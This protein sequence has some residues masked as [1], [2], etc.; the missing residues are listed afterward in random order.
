MGTFKTQMLWDSIRKGDLTATIGLLQSGNINLEERDENGQTFLMLACEFGELNIVRELFEANV[1]INAVDKDNWS[2]LMYSAKEGHLE[3]VIE[4]LERGANIEH[5]DLSGWTALM[6]ASYKGKHLVVQE[7]LERGANPN[8]KAELSM[9]SLA[10]AAG[11]GHTKVVEVLLQKGAKINTSDKYGTTALIWAARKGYLEIVE[12]LLNE[13]AIVDAVGM[14]SWTALLVATKGGFSEVVHQ[15]L[16]YD[17]NVNALDKDGFTALTIAAKEGNFQVV[18]DLLGKGAYVNIADRAGDTILIHAVKG[19]HVE[20][21]RALVKKFADVD[22]EGSEGKTALYWAIEKGHVEISRFILENNPDLEIATKDGDTALLRAVRNRNEQC[23]RLLLDKGARVSAVDKRGDTALHI[24]LRARSKRITELLLRNPRNSRLL[25]RPNKAGETPYNIDAYHQRQILTQIFGHRNLNANDGENLLGYDIYSSALADILSEPSLN[26]PITIGLYAKWGSGKSFLLSKLQREMKS[27][28]RA[29]KDEHF[30]FCWTLFI[31]LLLINNIIGLTLALSVRWEVGLGVGLGLFPLQYAFLGVVYVLSHKYNIQFA[32]RISLLLGR[33][34]MVLTLLLDV[35]FFNPKH[36]SQK[37]KYMEP[38][39]RF[40]FSESTKLT[41]VG[42]EKALAAMIGT[43]ADSLEREYG[44]VVA[45]LFRVFKPQPDKS[46]TGKFK[47]LCCIPYFVIVYAVFLSIEVGIYL[48]VSYKLYNPPSSRT[49]TQT[50][51]N[52]STTPPTGAS[53]QFDLPEDNTTI[54]AI[55]ITIGCI[56]VLALLS[57]IYTL[58]QAVMALVKSQRH[59][60]MQA[61]DQIDEIKID[62]LMQKLKYEVSLMGKLVTCMDKFTQNQTRLVVI[63]DGLDSCEQDKVLQVLDIIK[64]LF[65]DEDS[66]FITIL[67]ID[68]QVIIKGIDSNIL[69]TRVTFQDTNVN[70]FDYLRNVVHLP[71]YLQGQG[72]AVKKQDMAPS[73]SSASN[74]VSRHTGSESPS[75]TNRNIQHQESTISSSSIYE[76]KNKNRRSREDSFAMSYQSTFDLTSG[77]N[78]TDYFSDINPRSV[79]RLMNIV[80]VTGRILRAYN[81]DFNWHRLAS[82]INI[83]EQWPYRVSW[84]IFYFEEHEL[85]ENNTS[86]CSIYQKIESKIPVSKEVEPLL[87]IDR[88]VRKLEASLA[89][90]SGSNTMLN[91]AD[92]KK[93]LPCTIN[94]DPYFRKLIREL[95]KNN[96]IM[97][98]ADFPMGS[99]Y[100]GGPPP[101]PSSLPS[102]GKV[103]RDSSFTPHRLHPQRGKMPYCVPQPPY[104][105]DQGVPY[106]TGMPYPMMAPGYTGM[107]DAFNKKDAADNV[108][109]P[110][111]LLQNFQGERLSELDVQQVCLLLP[112]LK[113]ISQQQIGAYQERI[114]ENNINGLVLVSCDLDELRNV[115]NMSFGDWNLFKAG[116]KA[117]KSWEEDSLHVSHQTGLFG[118]TRPLQRDSLDDDSLLEVVRTPCSSDSIPVSEDTGVRPKHQSLCRQGSVESSKSSL[119]LGGMGKFEPIEEA[120]EADKDMAAEAEIKGR[121]KRKDSALQQVMYES[122]LLHEAL[123]MNFTEEEDEEEEGA[124]FSEPLLITES[125]EKKVS[126]SKPVKFNLGNFDSVQEEENFSPDKDTDTSPL[127]IKPDRGLAKFLS[128][129]SEKLH[130]PKVSPASSLRSLPGSQSEEGKGH[131]SLH[132]SGYTRFKTSGGSVGFQLAEKEDVSFVDEVKHPTSRSNK[133]KNAESSD[134]SPGARAKSETDLTGQGGVYDVWVP[135]PNSS[136]QNPIQLV[137]FSTEKDPND[138]EAMV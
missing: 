66:P 20:V 18:H 33:K 96:D 26:T 49:N 32:A 103:S 115:M 13:G 84:I 24:S 5:R 30:T 95:E 87:E 56:V 47:S 38:A 37:Q 90:K 6:W 126:P 117:L 113:G 138:Y 120:E 77:L 135:Q 27:F 110:N 1:D 11:R 136:G 70:G 92:L 129:S 116:I 100:G 124:V 21:V 105:T 130:R 41:S 12:M 119:P 94:L 118:D 15:L 86:L 122:G 137:A 45:K 7:L 53:D 9:T 68:P 40:L 57:N 132:S 131:P 3:I 74:D 34:L 61:A 31:I 111:H 2:A 58:G 16:E 82:W 109:D 44:T 36:R 107:Y 123:V 89:S 67:A 72:I 28:T 108:K 102:P 83:I 23:V 127:L 69:K 63:V 104:I 121:M 42:G 80:A 85:I 46:Y 17:P 81:I 55:L 35:L 65:S 75:K 10:W 8:I 99:M 4:L 79:K 76:P 125:G 29:N 101:G 93:F 91:V 98:R 51:T 134:L 88:N 64:A 50:F 78:K 48:L 25:Y 73:L 59:R 14:N 133:S 22:V 60:I 19:G 112:K 71:F 43:L 54:Y 128:T 62:G 106:M 114:Q 39:V 52:S 97:T